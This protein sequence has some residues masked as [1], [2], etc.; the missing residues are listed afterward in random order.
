MSR[1]P[2]PF[3]PL[4][5][6]V[7]VAE[8]QFDAATSFGDGNGSRNASV[9]RAFVDRE[10]WKNRVPLREQLVMLLQLMF[11]DAKV[12]LHHRPSLVNRLWNARKKD[13]DPPANSP[14]HLVYLPEDDHDVETRIRGL[15]GQHSDLGLARKMKR[16][17]K[18]RDPNRHKAKIRS[19]GFPKGP[20]RKIQSGSFR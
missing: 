14:E 18:N 19:R 10:H 4:S 9:F 11:G 6:K 17:A 7:Q 8:R 1:L 12:E 20:K 13:Y 15:H 2:R 16:I 3:I 5:I